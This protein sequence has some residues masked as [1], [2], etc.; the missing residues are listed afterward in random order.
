MSSDDPA[1][2]VAAT[3]G[4]PAGVYRD[5]L[6][7]ERGIVLWDGGIRSNVVVDDCRRLLAGFMHGAPTTTVGIN[8]L[9]VGAGRASW[10]VPPGPPPATAD[11]TT[12]HDPNPFTVPRSALTFDYLTDGAVASAPTNRLQIVARLGPDVPGWS[13]HPD[14]TLRE[15]GL[16]ADLDGTS[17][18]I[19]YVIHPAIPMDPVSTL[20]RTVWLVF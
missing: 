17:V 20:E 6:R 8:G 14:H 7:N 2:P 4:A 13:A 1:A 11:R 15:F 5:V 3:T 16:V 19:D 9:R 18:L 12:L 10:D